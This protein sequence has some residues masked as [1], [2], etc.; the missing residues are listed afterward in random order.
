MGTLNT[1]RVKVWFLLEVP[2]FQDLY[3]NRNKGVEQ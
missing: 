3:S 2:P 1:Y